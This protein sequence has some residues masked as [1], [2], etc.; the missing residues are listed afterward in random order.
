[1]G[2]PAVEIIIIIPISFTAT[3]TLKNFVFCGEW[4]GQYPVIVPWL[5]KVHLKGG[6][7]ICKYAN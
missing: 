2:V 1:M 7:K 3:L 4:I 5:N 6:N